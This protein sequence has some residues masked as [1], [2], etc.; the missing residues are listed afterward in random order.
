MKT[1]EIIRHMRLSLTYIINAETLEDAE[2]VALNAPV[3]NA[4]E[5][6]TMDDFINNSRE[7]SE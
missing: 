1:F 6:K 3:G 4:I 7:L 2:E 5:A